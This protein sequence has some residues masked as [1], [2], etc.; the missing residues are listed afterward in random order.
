MSEEGRGS[1]DRWGRWRREAVEGYRRSAVRAMADGNR[2]S[3]G[4]WGIA[5]DA[6]PRNY[7]PQT[8][9]GAVL[10]VPRWLLH[11]QLPNSPRS[12]T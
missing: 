12:P 8:T 9:T 10:K 6:R 2:A 1:S 11:W 4:L 3:S 5:G 7:A